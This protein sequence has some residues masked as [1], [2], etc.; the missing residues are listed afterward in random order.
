MTMK[1]DNT[2]ILLYCDF[3]TVHSSSPLGQEAKHM[4]RF[5]AVVALVVGACVELWHVQPQRMATYD[6]WK[7]I[8]GA[9]VVFLIIGLALGTG[10][11]RNP[12]DDE[13]RR[14]AK[15]RRR[16]TRYHVPR[17]ESED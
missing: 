4:R 7:H 14:V 12:V 9:T 6:V 5:I 11:R 16:A 13:R 10:R 3:F 17:M 8:L 1:I 15:E 2:G